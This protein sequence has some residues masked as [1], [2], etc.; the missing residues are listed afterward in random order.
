MYR[1][2][3]DGNIVKTKNGSQ[4]IEPGQDLGSFGASNISK[5][6]VYSSLL[7][8]RNFFHPETWTGKT[9][10]QGDEDWVDD[11]QDAVK[12]TIDFTRKNLIVKELTPK[13]A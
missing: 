13:Y 9:P 5:D 4:L 2:D 8:L 11:L 7:S 6:S 12:D 1:F 10:S 3:P